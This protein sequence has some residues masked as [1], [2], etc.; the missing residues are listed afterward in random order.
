MSREHAVLEIHVNSGSDVGHD[1][2][3]RAIGCV[4]EGVNHNLSF[5]GRRRLP[6]IPHTRE[7][8]TF[9]TGCIEA[10]ALASDH[11]IRYEEPEALPTDALIIWVACQGNV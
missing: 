6:E 10:V 1:L 7:S 3:D 9:S 11:R 8:R 4:Q 2:L 5:P